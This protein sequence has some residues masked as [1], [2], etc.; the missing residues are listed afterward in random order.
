M[1]QVYQP[2]KV[3]GIFNYEAVVSSNKTCQAIH[4]TRRLGEANQTKSRRIKNATNN[5]K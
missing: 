2:P 5:I 4:P 1:S 3:S